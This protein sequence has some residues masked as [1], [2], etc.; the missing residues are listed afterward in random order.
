MAAIATPKFRE[1]VTVA[2]AAAIEAFV[3]EQHSLDRVI[4]D[5]LALD[6]PALVVDV[7][8]MD[9]Y[10]HDV[11]LPWRDGLFLVYDTT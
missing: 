7:I 10:T 5:G 6:P 9:E 4:R 8:V 1:G 11:V 2:D 3:A